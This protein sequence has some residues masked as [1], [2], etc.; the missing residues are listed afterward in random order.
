MK[1]FI[2]PLLLLLAIGMLAAV[3]SA[4]SAVVGYVKYDCVAGLNLIAL[5]MDQGYAWASEIGTAYA[6]QTDAI[7]YWDAATQSWVSAVYYV[8]FEMWDPDFE[9]EPGSV[10]MVYALAPF[11]FYSI[12][13]MP[14]TNAQY[15]LLAGLNTVMVPLNKSALTLASEL[16][17]NIGVVDAV[18]EWVAASQSWNSAVYYVD[19]EMWDPD[20]P[21]SIGYPVMTY[22]LSPTTWPASPRGVDNLGSSSNRK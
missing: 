13:D 4:P 19:F 18:S 14:A 10:L 21:V 9:V 12:G 3:E 17:A 6:G 2:L 5:P 16:G 1:K 20:F 11:S 8:D 15:N 7:S 22:A